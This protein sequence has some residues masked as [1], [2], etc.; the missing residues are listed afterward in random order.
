MSKNPLVSL[1][2]LLERSWNQRQDS[3]FDRSLL[4]KN[5]KRVKISDVF[6]LFNRR[7]GHYIS[8]IYCDDNNWRSYSDRDVKVIPTKEVLSPS[9]AAYVYLYFQQN[10]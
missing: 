10:E 4:L 2:I 9:E 1:N 3:L 8:Q 5:I 7:I 6:F